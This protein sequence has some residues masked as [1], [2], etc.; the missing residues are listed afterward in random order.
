MAGPFQS[1]S[2]KAGHRR[3]AQREPSR[4]DFEK[5][6]NDPNSSIGKQTRKK[7]I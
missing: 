6:I 2:R 7:P 5:L 4:F 3:I 1:E